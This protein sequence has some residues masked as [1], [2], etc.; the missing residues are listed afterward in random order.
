TDLKTNYIKRC[1]AT[2]GDTIKIINMQL[3]VNGKPSV[4]PEKMQYR[5]FIQTN[6]TI[7]AKI[8]RKLDISEY[9]QY[10]GGYVVYTT[11]ATVQ[12]LKSMSFVKD[13]VTTA[14]GVEGDARVFPNNSR[15]MWN[16]DNFG[17]LVLPKKGMTINLDSNTI[18][19]YEN[20]ISK[21][22]G[23]NEV[24]VDGN[25]LI[26]DGKPTSTYTFRQNYY[27]MMGD[28]RNNSLDSRFWGFVPEDHV[29][30]K[31]VFIWLSLDYSAPL[32]E[33]VRWN[34]LFKVV[35]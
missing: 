24:K 13:V 26:I 16:E 25:Q 30:G 19:L 35:D 27:W 15:F 9:Q 11:E 17:P 12:K 6:E 1:V 3:F 18:A 23:Y 34:R 29:V 31:A 28:N 32:L 22:E 5:Y 8:F 4:N 33:K 7:N 2:A 10:E 21:Y 14:R 20:T